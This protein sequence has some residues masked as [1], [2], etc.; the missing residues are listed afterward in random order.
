MSIAYKVSMWWSLPFATD[1][2][3]LFSVTFVDF[4]HLE[5]YD[6]LISIDKSKSYSTVYLNLPDLKSDHLLS[7]PP[8]MSL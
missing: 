5:I 7:R 1:S 6:T 4:S 2:F 8:N 3:L